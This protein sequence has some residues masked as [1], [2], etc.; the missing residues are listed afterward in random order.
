MSSPPNSLDPGLG[1][2]VEA[3]EADWL[4]YT[5]LLTY[6]HLNGTAGTALIPGLATALP[7][8]SANGLTCTH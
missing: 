8:I 3:S 6:A 7:T 1:Y 4:V 2:T 5:P